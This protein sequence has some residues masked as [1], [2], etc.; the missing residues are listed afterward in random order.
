MER[1]LTEVFRLL[2]EQCR[3][4]CTFRQL[5]SFG[6]FIGVEWSLLYL[7]EAFSKYDGTDQSTL[8][9]SQFLHFCIDELNGLDILSPVF[10]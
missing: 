5:L 3:E 10:A 2:D 1:R 9:L 6:N 8:T 7:Q 4:E